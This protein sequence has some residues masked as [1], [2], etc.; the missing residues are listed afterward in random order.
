MSETTGIKLNY[1]IF[2]DCIAESGGKVNILGVFSTI[3]SKAFPA[4]HQKFGIALNLS[5]DPIEHT[6][7]LQF[8]DTNGKDV[9]PKTPPLKFKCPE[10]GDANLNITIENLPLQNPG[11]LT[12]EVLVDNK[13]TGEK[14]LIVSK[15]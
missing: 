14:D 1:I 11:F 13:K 6:L 10:F 7:N 9:I 5:G 8:R 4:V 2:C 3:Y 15:V 12:V